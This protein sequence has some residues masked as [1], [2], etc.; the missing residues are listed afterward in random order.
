MA[1]Q[2]PEWQ[3]KVLADNQLTGQYL[4]GARKWFNPVAEV[5]A[6]HHNSA[7]RPLLVAVN[8]S[9]GSGKSTLCHYLCEYLG[10]EHRLSCLALS[11]DDFYLTAPQRR[12]LA[13]DIHPLFA[14]RGVPGTHDMGLLARTLDSLLAGR[15]T[16]VPRFDKAADDR[17]PEADWEAVPAGVDMV[18]LEGWCL[19]ATPQ[20]IDELAAPVN[21]LESAEDADGHW[22]NH[23]NA[24][25]SERF[26]PLYQR[27]DEWLMLQAPSFDCVYRWRLEQEQKLA[28]RRQGEGLMDE[29]QI[30]RFI[31]H[32]QRLTEHC[33]RQLPP[34]VNHVFR[35]DAERAVQSYSMNPGGQV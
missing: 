10:A 23:V 30:A 13:I 26:S 22:R 8:G 24:V 7:G 12:Q 2:L 6:A 4:V 32:Y 25:L 33:L 28:R 15:A 16:R 34:R 9:Q 31:Q 27:V 20:P 29:A 1:E 21:A 18:L 5:L 14:T 19:G 3:R 35:L 11:L 17:V